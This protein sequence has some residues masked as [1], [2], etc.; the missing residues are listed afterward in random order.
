V[1]SPRYN[2]GTIAQAEDPHSHP[3]PSA[4][5]S[6]N[7]QNASSASP[8][9]NATNNIPP[10]REVIWIK[11][12]GA[13]PSYP[14]G[15]LAYSVENVSGW[16]NDATSDARFLKG[17]ATGNNG[18]ATFGGAPHTHTMLSHTHT[19]FPH[20]HSI[21]STGL[22]APASSVEM[23]PGVGAPALPRHNHPMNV[24]A[25]NTGNLNA[26]TGG[27]TT[28][29][30]LEPINRRLRVLRNSSGGIQTRIIGLYTG[31]VAALNPVLSV[32]N[33]ANGTP[34]MRGYF[35]RD[36]GSDSV[37]STAGF[38]SH[39]HAVGNHTHSIP[40]HAHAVTVGTSNTGWKGTASPAPRGPSPTVDHTHTSG[41]TAAAVPTISSNGDDVTGSGSHLPP[42]KEVHFVRL[43][44]TVVN[45]PLAVPEL[46]IS[47][48]SSVTVP[49]FSYGDDLD[50]LSSLTDRITVLTDRSHDYP[51]LVVQTIPLDGGLQT[52]S[53]TLAGEDMTLTIAVEGLPAIERLED[54]LS[55][56]RV[57]WSPVGGTPGWYAP[58]GW[59]VTAPAPNVKVVQV[60]MVRQPW[61]T[62]PEPS[63]Y[64]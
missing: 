50:R 6:R 37:N 16:T 30:S 38:T 55:N 25:G 15:V 24:L 56:D 8:G 9:T 2:G 43:N 53:T 32:C 29:S 41:N 64:L 57:Y 62:T 34:D 33:G 20:D 7:A 28:I 23:G 59:T 26:N 52:V 18:G 13:Q 17:V 47:E 46:R 19:G 63:V 36:N 49:S 22:S 51:R 10:T 1:S 44:G 58:G 5:G 40:S 4:T 60:T 31:T 48:F 12:D 11:S 21:S 42:Y 3:R 54:M 35:A 27:L 61:P 45:D 14:Q 39:T